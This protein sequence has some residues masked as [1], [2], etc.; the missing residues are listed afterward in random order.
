MPSNI[1][2]FVFSFRFLP[3]RIFMYLL[4]RLPRVCGLA[5]RSNM[6]FLVTN[7]TMCELA[8]RSNMRFLA[9][10]MTMR[11]LKTALIWEM[12]CFATT[13]TGFPLCSVLPNHYHSAKHT[14]ESHPRRQNVVTR[15][16]SYYDQ[17]ANAALT[18][19]SNRS[20]TGWRNPVLWI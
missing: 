7:M 5:H 6:P 20:N 16:M 4:Q 2:N 18:W 13:V 10:S 9:T 19:S 15:P 1:M 14:A 3:T 11:I 8:H 12:S 17:R